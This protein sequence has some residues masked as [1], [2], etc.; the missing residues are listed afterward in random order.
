M[1]ANVKDNFNFQKRIV[2]I[3][4][5]LFLVKIFAWYLTNSVAV[6]TDAL[7]S[8][9]NVISGFIGLYSLYVSAQPADKNHPYGHGKVEFISAGI[10][11]ALITVAGLIIIY[12]SINN[13]RHPH[14]L[15]QL[16]YGMLL[17]GASAL[18]NY[19]L[20]AAAIKKGRQT[21]SLPLVSSGKHLQ[22]DTWSTVG[23]VVGLAL[24]YFTHIVWIDSAVAMLFALLIIY[25]GYKILRESVAGI[26]DE[27]DDDLV[28]KLVV[29]LE[30]NRNENWI[31]LHNLRIIKYGSILHLDCHLTVPWYFNVHQA[32]D[33][34]ERLSAL[35]RE[36]FGESVELFVHT[37]GCL[38]FS[39][40]I[41]TK[42]DCAERKQPLS[43]RITWN[44]QN[45]ISNEKHKI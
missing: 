27:A 28:E 15:T 10:E 42:K 3:G 35:V 16:D 1:Q 12:E 33:E 41:C 24:I 19:F 44:I 7:E 5:V 23:I 6:L 13:L 9:V 22:S 20:G 26:M 17:V 11:G 34:V 37:D 32:H 8:I 45:V 29:F 2:A 39:C 36:N 25:T 21:N 43:Q 18:V 31:D 40:A 14:T 30:A 4:M 38:D